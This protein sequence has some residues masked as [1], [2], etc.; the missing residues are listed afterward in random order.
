LTTA[1]KIRAALPG[2]IEA[3]VGLDRATVLLPHWTKAQYEA[4]LAG[5]R[6]PGSVHRK[7]LVAETEG[8][9]TG[10]AVVKITRIAGEALAELESIAVAA[11]SRGH[12]IGRAL[13]LEVIAYARLRGAS[14]MELEVRSLNFEAIS[15]YSGLRFVVEATRR[16]YYNN[17]EDDALL[18]RL[19]F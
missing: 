12:G 11:A 2:D 18:M 17:P 3:I 1:V 6:E 15:L 8:T 13:S 9:L 4:A 14:S 16:R 7:L 5:D 19:A 10:F